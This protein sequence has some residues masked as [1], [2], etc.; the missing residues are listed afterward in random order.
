MPSNPLG[1][2]WSSSTHH[3]PINLHPINHPLSSNTNHNKIK[4]AP[5]LGPLPLLVPRRGHERA[6]GRL[7]RR[8]LVGRLHGHRQVRSVRLIILIM[9]PCIHRRARSINWTHD[10]Y[11]PVDPPHRLSPNPLTHPQKMQRA[12]RRPR[13]ARAQVRCEQQREQQRGAGHAGLGGEAEE[14]A[15]VVMLGGCRVKARRSDTAVWINFTVKHD[16]RRVGQPKQARLD[17]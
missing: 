13:Q 17:D 7:P 14:S 11:H 16:G 3:P 2:P 4:R 9:H 15:A 6:L 10:A 5:D 1:H 8:A 12:G